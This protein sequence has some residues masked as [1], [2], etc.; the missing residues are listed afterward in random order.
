MVS[1]TAV[2]DTQLN[3]IAS[4]VEPS[5]SMKFIGKLFVIPESLLPDQ[6]NFLRGTVALG[7]ACCFV[8][9][10]QSIMLFVVKEFV[11]IV[12]HQHTCGIVTFLSSTA[13]GRACGQ[14]RPVIACAVLVN[15]GSQLKSQIQSLQQSIEKLLV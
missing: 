15:E 13:L 14:S 1:M 2:C 8:I 11:V 9:I 7:W 10:N 12:F 5:Y 3:L 4:M 6:N